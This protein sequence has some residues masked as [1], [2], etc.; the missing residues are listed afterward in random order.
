MSETMDLEPI[1]A[2]PAQTQVR[3]PA[4]ARAA[5]KARSFRFP[6]RRA[7]RERTA[8]EIEADRLL[9]EDFIARRGVTVCPKGYASGAVPTAY[10]FV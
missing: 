10:E 2:V 5:A 3:T 9:V 6:V 7:K 8:A 4:E 1:A